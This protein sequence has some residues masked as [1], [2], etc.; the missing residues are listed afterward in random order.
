MKLANGSGSIVCLDSTGEKRRKPYAV[1]VTVGWSN[2]KQIRKYIGY[3]ATQ[4]EALMALAEYHKG[5]VNL[6]LANITVNELFDHWMKRVEKKG[7][8]DSVIRTHKIAKSRFEQLGRK[9]VR[10]VKAVHWQTWLDH[11]ELKPGTKKKVRS[12]LQQM[13]EYAIQND[14]VQKNYATSLEINE[15]IQATGSVFT[16]EEIQKLWEHADQREIRW[17]LIMIYTGMRIGELLIIHR[18]QINFEENYITGGI[19]TKAGK[20]R[21]IPLHDKIVPL[22]KDEL[23]DNKWL[24]QNSANGATSYSS[25]GKQIRQ[26]LKELKMDHKPHDCRKTAVSLMHSAGIP[27]EVIRIIIGHSGKGVTESV[28]LFKQPKELVEYINMIKNV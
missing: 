21:I 11:L 1:R 13:L 25:A 23:G 12:T 7:L 26:K 3:Y 24:V 9:K 22:V 4:T 27:M 6:D 16:P 15:K 8:S 5:V 19:K 18:K 14:I 20:D 28:Y 2:G 10:D 17:L